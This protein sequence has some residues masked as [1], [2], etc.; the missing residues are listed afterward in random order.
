MNQTQRTLQEFKTTLAPADV[1]DR[2]KRFFS[3]NVSI[4]AAF[5]ENESANHVAFRGQGGEELIIAARQEHG[6]TIVSGSTYMFDAQ[7]A[8][9]FTT[10]PGVELTEMMLPENPSAQKAVTHE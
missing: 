1:L 2:A 9:F 6:F 10:L 5:L 3:R 8:R 7:V 4:Y